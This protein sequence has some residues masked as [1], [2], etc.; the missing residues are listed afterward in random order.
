MGG[1]GRVGGGGAWG[2][3]DVGGGGRVGVGVEETKGKRYC[4]KRKQLVDKIFGAI[5]RVPPRKGMRQSGAK[6]DAASE[7]E[8]CSRERVSSGLLQPLNPG[9]QLAPGEGHLP[10]VHHADTLHGLHHRHGVFVDDVD[11][12]SHCYRRVPRHLRYEGFHPAY[13]N[14]NGIQYNVNLLPS[15]N[16]IARGMFYGA[17]DTHHTFTPIIKHYTAT[18][19]NKHP[20]KKSFI[21]L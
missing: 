9:R 20:G 11:D 1:G 3:G 13:K 4:A 2:V 8:R 10:Q 6:A 15:V 7:G 21:D 19:A 14:I 5:L 12:G 17:K 18:T 16:T